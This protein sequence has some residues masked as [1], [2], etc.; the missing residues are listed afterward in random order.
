MSLIPDGFRL[1]IAPVGWKQQPVI[2]V[3]LQFHLPGNGCLS[4]A[5]STP[6][7]IYIT[8]VNLLLLDRPE[9]NPLSDVL[10]VLDPTPKHDTRRIRTIRRYG[11][12][13]LPQG[14]ISRPS[15]AIAVGSTRS[16][17]LQIARRSRRLRAIR[18]YGSGTLLRAPTTRPS[19]LISPLI[20]F[21]FPATGLAYVPIEESL[22]LYVESPVLLYSLLLQLC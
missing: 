5:R 4:D 6:F 15:K 14:P 17:S 7:I 19:T 10:C 3:S 22:T 1:Q 21:P 8:L 18:R 2:P 9:C 13:I 12:G 11:S 16:P 20:N